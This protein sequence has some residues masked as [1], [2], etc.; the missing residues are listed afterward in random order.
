M[1][2]VPGKRLEASAGEGASVRRASDGCAFLEDSVDEDDAIWR[3]RQLPCHQ[4]LRGAECHQ[5]RGKNSTWT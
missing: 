2:L 5:D 3:G 4:D 1:K